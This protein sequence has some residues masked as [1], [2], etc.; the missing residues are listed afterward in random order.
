[1]SFPIKSAIFGLTGCAL[2]TGFALS[3]AKA[4]PKLREHLYN[5]GY[6]LVSAK[7]GIEAKVW[8]ERAKAYKAEPKGEKLLFADLSKEKVNNTGEELKQKCNSFT[9]GDVTFESVEKIYSTIIEWCTLSVKEYIEAN[10]SKGDNI[11]DGSSGDS[12]WEGIFDKYQSQINNIEKYKNA[13]KTEAKSVLSKFCEEAFPLKKSNKNRD[14]VI[15]ANSWCV[16]KAEPV[17]KQPA[18]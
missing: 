2:A 15:N 17:Q 5:E 4:S 11:L 9:E 3:Q 1:M 18:T 14:D 12:D 6:E 13:K 16:K 10:L 8:A 7:S